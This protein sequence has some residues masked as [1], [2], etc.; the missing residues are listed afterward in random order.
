MSTLKR[1]MTCYTYDVVVLAANR[2]SIASRAATDPDDA[3]GRTVNAQQNIYV[4]QDD[5]EATE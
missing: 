4:L 3:D 1:C 2:A 5:S